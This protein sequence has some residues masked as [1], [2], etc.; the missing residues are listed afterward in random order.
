MRVT[1]GDGDDVFAR[2]YDASGTPVGGD[3][4]ANS[5]TTGYQDTP[6]V[7]ATSTGEFVVVWKDD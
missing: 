5:C 6:A 1:W 2:R 7:H 4:Q 3:L